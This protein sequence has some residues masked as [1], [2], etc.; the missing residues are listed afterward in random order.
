[1]EINNVFLWKIEGELK[2]NKEEDE[3]G[4]ESMI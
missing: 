1:M 2:C 3:Y 4:I